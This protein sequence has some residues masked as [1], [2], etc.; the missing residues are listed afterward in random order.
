MT[1]GN[2]GNDWWGGD[3]TGDNLYAASIVAICVAIGGGRE[4][5]PHPTAAMAPIAHTRHVTLDT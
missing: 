3:R 1:T 4:L 2:A 5:R